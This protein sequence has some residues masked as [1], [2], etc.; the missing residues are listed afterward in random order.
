MTINPPPH[1]QTE[2]EALSTQHFWTQVN[3]SR[4]VYVPK[5]YKYPLAAE[6]KYY[7]QKHKLLK[8]G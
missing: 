3:T 6:N 4:K 8:M 7:C 1:S 2:P 5:E